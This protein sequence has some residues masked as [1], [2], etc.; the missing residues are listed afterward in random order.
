MSE[1][2]AASEPMFE[3]EEGERAVQGDAQTWE[4]AGLENPV[5]PV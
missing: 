5:G 3:R 2:Y 1:G 4:D